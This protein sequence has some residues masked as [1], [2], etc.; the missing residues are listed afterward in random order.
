VSRSALTGRAAKALAR[1]R[2]VVV[3]GH[4]L[5]AHTHSYVHGAFVKAFR[6]LGAETVWTDDPS[7]LAG[8]DLRG[9]LF[10]TEGQVMAGLPL[11]R[12]CSYVLHNDPDEGAEIADRALLLQV[13][14]RDVQE[15]HRAGGSAEKLDGYTYVETDERGVVTLLQPWATDLLPGEFDFD[16]E[17]PRWGGRA[18]RPP[19]AAWVGT[20]GDGLFGNVNELAG[21]RAACAE[22]GVEFVHRQGIGFRE[23]RRLILDSVMAPAIVG[24]WQLEHG[25]VP[26]RIF[27]NISYGRLGL[28]NSPS[29]QALF[30]EE[31]VCDVDTHE[32]FQAGLAQLGARGSL[33]AQ[34]REIQARHTYVQRIERILELVP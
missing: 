10:L 14:S 13:L 15:R 6:A 30:E 31:L 34:M 23:N 32:L 8:L 2:R 1:F 25:Y 9:T 11:R 18:P 16:V 3:W 4:P 19:T 12:D 29:V 27:K 28:T 26:C 22:A 7:A 17:L 33:V 21:F 24:A 5:H 20:I